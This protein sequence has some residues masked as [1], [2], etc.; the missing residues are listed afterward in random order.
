V[1]TTAETV[2]FKNKLSQLI[3]SIRLPWLLFSLLV[4]VALVKLG[5]W[6]LQR[7]DEKYQ[8]LAR[9]EQLKKHEALSL[10]QV[11]KLAQ[12]NPSNLA[13]SINDL[14][15]KITAEFNPNYI[16]L[17]DNQT[18]KNALGYRVF[19][20]IKADNNY[21]LVNLGWLLG[22]INRQQLPTFTPINGKHS[23]FGN[24]RKIE[25]GVLLQ[26]QEFNNVQWPLRV[27]QI[28]L[29][30]FSALIG[31]KLLPFVV[32]LDKN[33][34][35]GFIKNWHPIVMPAKKHQAYAFQWFSLAFA[36]LVLMAWAS[37]KSAAKNVN[38]NNCKQKDL[39]QNNNKAN[40][41]E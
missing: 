6:Q 15:V 28:E 16:F 20:L 35:L 33:E 7:A 2:S 37:F 38:K 9:I 3:T 39:A 8:R 31:E 5:L 1:P 14:P 26:A 32:Y 29:D 12:Q 4:F 18:N 17:L 24:I 11:I 41:N 34:P 27:Q 19:Q 10:P 22:S 13:E 25:M 21:L 36:W 23:F 30:K 40:E